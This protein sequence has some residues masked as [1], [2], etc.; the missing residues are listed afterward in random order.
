VTTPSPTLPIETDPDDA[1]AEGPTD[2]TLTPSLYTV[3]VAG[4]SIQ[5]EAVDRGWRARS[6]DHF[7][8]DGRWMYRTFEAFPTPEVA[9]Q[10]ASD[11]RRSGEG[12]RA[13]WW[14]DPYW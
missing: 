11:A 13:D 1:H 10:A 2:L 7:V 12:I 3:T 6:C 5:I 4:R 8:A 14:T 9:A